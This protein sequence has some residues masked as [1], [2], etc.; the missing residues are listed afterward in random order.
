MGGAGVASAR[1]SY[2]PYY[3]PALLAEHKHKMQFSL[4]AGAAAREVNIAES[5]DRLSEVDVD[6]TINQFSQNPVVGNTVP[7][8]I[9][10]DIRTI[11][12]ELTSLS[13]QNGLQLMPSASFGMQFGNFGFGAYGLSEVTA[14]AVIDPNR[15]NFI[16]EEGGFY[17]SYDEST[18]Q[19]S[20]S[21]QTEYEANSLEY[22]LDSGL[23][24][25]KLTGLAYMEIPIAYGHSFT[26]FL[27]DINC[28]ASFKIMPGYS[29]DQNVKIDTRSGNVSDDMNDA[30]KQDTSFGVDLGL[31]YKPVILPNLSIGIVG[32][33][34]NTPRFKTVND[35]TLEVKPQ[36][37]AGLA[38]DLLL[39][40][41]TVAIDAD[42]TRNET[43]IP[44]Y[45]S[46]FIGGGLNFHP[47]SWLSLRVG[48]M[49]NIQEDNE[50]LIWTGGFGAGVKW[51]QMDLSGQYS[52][53]TGEYDGDS[54]P[55]YGRIQLSFVSKWF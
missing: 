5:I 36:V 14:Y 16:V 24:Y 27:G 46:Q 6:D 52:S 54:I 4:S 49:Q 26:T 42:L 45:Q 15:L 50:G 20:L 11:R 32:K 25:L 1:G 40:R 48:A 13:E 2:A 9:Q 19:Y 18:G 35:D 33:N 21:N 28:G 17:F 53:K 37:R 8:S 12:N 22:A 44:E 41:L 10:N 30:D 31:L 3:N 39:D 7:A 43:F 23:T 55:K 47:F 29:Y 38:Y 34:L 51:F